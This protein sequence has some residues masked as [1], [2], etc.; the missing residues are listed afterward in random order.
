MRPWSRLLIGGLLTV[1][2]A[3]TSGDRVTD[4]DNQPAG[5][6]VS[7]T[8]GTL[9]FIAD[10]LTLTATVTNA[11]GEQLSTAVTWTSSSSS[12]ASV[13]SAGLVTA[14]S[15]G[16]AT[17]EAGAGTVAGSA[18]IT[19]RQDPAAMAKTVGDAQD[20]LTGHVLPDTLVIQVT[21]A[22]GTPVADAAVEWS[23]ASGGGVLDASDSQTDAGGNA[24][25]VWRLGQESGAQSVD[26]DVGTLSQTFTATGTLPDPARLELTPELDTIR[27]LQDT[28][29]LTATVYAADDSII[30]AAQVTWAST[31]QAVATVD[32]TGL[33]TALSEG[34][35]QIVAIAGSVGDTATLVVEVPDVPLPTIDSITPSVLIEGDVATVSGT[36]FVTTL[37]DNTVVLDGETIVLQSATTTQIQFVVPTFDCKPPRGAT[38]SVATAGGKVSAQTSVSP[39][40][41]SVFT[42]AV[43]DMQ[44]RF[45][46]G[47][48]IHLDAGPADAEYLIGVLSASNLPSSLTPVTVFSTVGESVSTAPRP[49]VAVAAGREAW[50]ILAGARSRTSG[51]A[52]LGRG[53]SG[54]RGWAD[55]LAG[56]WALEADLRAREERLFQELGGLD[57]MRAAAA[58][59]FGASAAIDSLPAVGDTIEVLTGFSGTCSARDTVRAVTQL[60]GDDAIWLWDIDNPGPDFTL[61][62]IGTMDAQYS[63]ITASTLTDYFG[64]FADV[65]G[66]NRVFVLMTRN[67]N[68]VKDLG[69]FV[70]S[71]D[72]ATTSSCATSNEAE[73][74]YGVVP[75]SA[76]AAG[77]VREKDALLGFYPSLIAHEVT[78]IIQRTQSLFNGAALKSRWEIEGGA[79]LAE[80]LVGYK[81][82]GDAPLQDL[83]WNEMVA[84]QDW[85]KNWM[86][87]MARYFGWGDSNVRIALAPE[88]CTWIGRV[89]DGNDGP[90]VSSRAVYGVPS[91]LLRYLLDRFGPSFAGGEEALMREMTG[92]TSAGYATVEAITGE[93]IE[94]TLAHFGAAL[95][96]D[97]RINNWNTI[98]SWNVT[99]IFTNL[100]LQSAFENTNLIPY[101]S[102]DAAPELS[103]SVRGGSNAYLR[104][105][106]PGNP[107]PTSIRLRTPAGADPPDH[108][109]LWIFRLR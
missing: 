44:I 104:W 22:G 65:D 40:T 12:V 4:V 50:P 88:Q 14:A 13:S 57:A 39:A 94:V 61:A 3:C 74:F 18:T 6:A 66:N 82:M 45:D 77:E 16:T 5:V 10:T 54:L 7:P 48:C 56:H 29:R 58:A 86:F 98:T 37:A 8:S 63:A 62:E 24:E 70:W 2:A 72:L 43:Q 59:G 91:M 15:V 73:I 41:D 101:H 33:A 19:V 84:G 49:L 78:H 11:S 25:A 1:T 105:E 17:I 38:L 28:L 71:G 96:A 31:A 60:V 93:S 9:T 69:G 89:E 46:G 68:E 75:D 21:D 64:D 95:W 51:F 92:S 97:G 30:P 42:L 80:Q 55:P 53:V 85:Y 83:G 32:S 52:S 108:M 87:D 106:P 107:K 100:E 67:V 34:T 90:C 109:A 102:Q 36:N 23:V 79:T 99:E 81:V 103:V 47:D 35:T 27:V 26:V 76:G 20:G